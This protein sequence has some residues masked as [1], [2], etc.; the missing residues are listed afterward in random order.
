M[1]RWDKE[2]AFMEV[3]RAGIGTGTG[4][5]SVSWL[6]GAHTDAERAEGYRAT[7]WRDLC[8]LWLESGR[9]GP[10]TGT[11]M[12]CFVGWLAEQR[13]LGKRRVSSRSLAQ[14]LSVVRTVQSRMGWE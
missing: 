12:V 5:K 9:D 8:E 13:I 1:R 6:L 11:S 10:M 14:D 7:E 4:A 2:S 3:H